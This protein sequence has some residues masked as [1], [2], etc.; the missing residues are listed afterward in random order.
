V[1]N[2]STHIHG[3]LSRR[4]REELS[5]L[6]AS[7]HQHG[8]L[9]NAALRL[10]VVSRHAATMLGQKEFWL[11]FVCADQEYRVA[12]RRLAQFCQQHRERAGHG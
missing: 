12:V 6:Q 2:R 11:E 3:V 5:A 4:A 8:A 10:F 7:V 1:L 9:R